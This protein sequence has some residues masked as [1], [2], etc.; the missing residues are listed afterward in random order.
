MLQSAEVRRCDGLQYIGVHNKLYENWSITVRNLKSSQQWPWSVPSSWSIIFITFVS[1]CYVFWY[2]DTV[3]RRAVDKCLYFNQERYRDIISAFHY[4][5]SCSAFVLY[6][7]GCR[8]KC[9]VLLS[10]PLYILSF[11]PTPLLL[12]FCSG[13]HL[14]SEKMTPE[15]NNIPEAYGGYEYVTW[16]Y[17]PLSTSEMSG[18]LIFSLQDCVSDK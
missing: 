8:S 17:A 15:M 7:R 18:T 11:A 16:A 10:W 12:G 6:I 13:S 5:L 3:I 1:R 4:I 2:T 14:Y 9:Y